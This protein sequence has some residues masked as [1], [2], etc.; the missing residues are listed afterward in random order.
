MATETPPAVTATFTQRHEALDASYSSA[1]SSSTLSK[2]LTTL[3]KSFTPPSESLTTFSESPSTLSESLST[4]STLSE[5]LST[6]SESLSTLSE[7]LSTLS[8][9]LSALSAA[10]ALPASSAP[11]PELAQLAGDELG[12]LLL[13]LA[14]DVGG[15]D[16][17]HGDIVGLLEGRLVTGH[18]ALAATLAA[19][20]AALAAPPPAAPA[21]P[22]ASPAS[23]SSPASALAALAAELALDE[24]GV[25]LLLVDVLSHAL[26]ALAAQLGELEPLLSWEAEARQAQ[27]WQARPGLVDGG[28]GYLAL[29]ETV[30]P[31]FGVGKTLGDGGIASYRRGDNVNQ[32]HG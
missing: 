31:I 6:L 18:D 21:A 4:L 17:G 24:L 29:L 12:A 28:D 14:G 1:S 15:E 20:L 30:D 25:L 13:L 23:A 32:T 8:E 5:S 11:E 3:S 22:A 19:T 26:D 7:S 27:L 10:A 16:V 9:S 2:S